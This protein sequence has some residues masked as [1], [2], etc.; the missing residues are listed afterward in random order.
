MSRVKVQR[1]VIALGCVRPMRGNKRRKERIRD[2]GGSGS[3]QA[4]SPS[5]NLIRC[6][7]NPDFA[8][9]RDLDRS[10]ENNPYIETI[11]G[12]GVEENVVRIFMG[13]SNDAVCLPQADKVEAICFGSNLE[14]L[15]A[16]N[17]EVSKLFVAWLDERSFA[18]GKGRS[19]KYRNPLTARDL[20]K[21]L[22]KPV[23]CLIL[24][25]ISQGQR[26][27]CDFKQA[28]PLW[29]RQY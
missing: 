15:Q 20:Y 23:R 1:G 6:E 9:R 14:S 4:P 17:G 11:A 12:L 3:A 21:E 10:V 16:E 29:W 2:D 27:S 7:W 25:P 19:R 26:S 22:K 18:E 5:L 24:T 8:T 28:L 13:G